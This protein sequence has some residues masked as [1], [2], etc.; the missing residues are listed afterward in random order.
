MKVVIDISDKEYKYA[1][2]NK[3][4]DLNGT[5]LGEIITNGVSLPKGH[6]RLIDADELKNETYTMTEWN[7]D[8][9]QI[10]YKAS[11]DDAP[12]VIPADKENE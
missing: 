11:L 6:G 10:I 4:L 7:G 1:V 3:F 5:H 9:H 12:T 8:V 2:E